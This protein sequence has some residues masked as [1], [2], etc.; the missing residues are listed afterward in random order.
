VP[1]RKTVENVLKAVSCSS[2]WSWRDRSFF[3]TL[4]RNCCRFLLV[5][6]LG[7]V[8]EPACRGLDLALMFFWSGVNSSNWC[9]WL[10][11]LS[12]VESRI[13]IKISTLSTIDLQLSVCIDLS[14]NKDANHPE[15]GSLQW[16]CITSFHRP[17]TLGMRG[18]CPPSRIGTCMMYFSHGSPRILHKMFATWVLN[19]SW[20]SCY[21]IVWGLEPLYRN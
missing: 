3:A 2:C 20:K 15:I 16:A 8:E 4:C 1:S 13:E 10:S 19:P 6:D 9:I 21:V 17:V 12:N 11:T 14:K 7:V 5:D 18:S